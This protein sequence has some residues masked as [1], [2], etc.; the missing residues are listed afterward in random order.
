MGEGGG[1]WM[2]RN[3]VSRFPLLLLLVYR[4]DAYLFNF[5]V[6]E[7]IVQLLWRSCCIFT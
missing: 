6:W 2:V 4:K 1:G 7:K 3:S 5:L